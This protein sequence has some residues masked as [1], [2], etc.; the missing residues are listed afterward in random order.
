MATVEECEAAFERLAARLDQA[1]Q[2]G[3]ARSLDRTLSCRLR[4][5]D[6]VYSARIK[7]GRL[8]DV[9]RAK[10]DRAKVRLTMTSDD[11]IA[12]VDGSL[13]LSSAWAGGRVKV[14][15]SITDMVKLRSVF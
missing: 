9:E 14:D 2:G 5:L 1:V 11:L 8:V 4:D 13:R 15:A 6:V 10:N 7:E 12:L 3:R